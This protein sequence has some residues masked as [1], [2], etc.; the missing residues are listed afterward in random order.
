MLNA[1]FSQ[2]VHVFTANVSNALLFVEDGNVAYRNSKRKN[3]L[4]FDAT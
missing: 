1:V 2:L 4:R 3:L